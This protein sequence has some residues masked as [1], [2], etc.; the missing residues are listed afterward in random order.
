MIINGLVYNEKYIQ[1]FC[2]NGNIFFNV[3]K[4]GSQCVSYVYLVH[5]VILFFIHKDLN[6]QIV[7]N[8]NATVLIPKLEFEVPPSKGSKINVS[9]VFLMKTDIEISQ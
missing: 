6:R 8:D 7:Q 5:S 1:C 4:F 2:Q 9:F 3:F